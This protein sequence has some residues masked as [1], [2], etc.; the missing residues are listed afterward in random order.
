M[1]PSDAHALARQLRQLPHIRAAQVLDRS[2]VSTHPAAQRPRN[3]ALRAANEAVHAG[4][5]NLRP[6]RVIRAVDHQIPASASGRMVI[7]GRL[8]D[9]CAELERLSD[10]AQA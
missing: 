5:A 7:S 8:A 2:A 10:A 4:A 3:T 1:A 6:L 9:V